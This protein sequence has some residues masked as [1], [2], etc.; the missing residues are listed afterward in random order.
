MSFSSECK[1]ELSRLPVG[2]KSCCRMAEL[3]ALFM[4]A[5]SLNLL[6]RGLMSV[7]FTVESAAIVKRV[8]I[9]LQKEMDLTPQVHS[10]TH[11]RFGGSKKWVLTLGP[12]QSPALLT[13][14][15]MMEI[16]AHGQPYLRGT[17]PRIALSRV[18]CMR[19]FLRGAMLAAGTVSNPDKGYR[20][21]LV[22]TEE[23]FR[24]PLGKCLQRF[25]LPVQSSRRKEADILYF[26]QGEQVATFLT[27]I[28]AHQAVMKLED[29]RIKKQVLGGVNRAMNCDAANLEKQ[30]NAS[31]QQLDRIAQLISSD[32][33]S[34]L[35]LTLQ[36]IAKA[37]IHAPD[38]SLAELGEM[39]STP[40][41]K[42]GVNHRM[43]RLMQYADIKKEATTIKKE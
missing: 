32:Q 31:D 34:A 4:A 17:Y 42:S 15:S 3:A 6:G 12:K 7:Q 19:A 8:F 41:G 37:R 43:R 40:I 13:A 18:C 5:G 11:A 27:L 20:L 28:G 24:L 21:E 38:A 14:F 23:I 29:A 36:E 10:V 30:M 1:E 35:P 33:F 2:D 9:L 25:E 39:L 22:T 16:D 26:T